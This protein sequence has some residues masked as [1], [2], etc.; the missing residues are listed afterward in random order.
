MKKQSFNTDWTFGLQGDIKHPVCLPHDAMLV[1]GR[2]AKSPGGS[3]LGYFQGGTYEYEKTFIFSGDLEHKHFEIQF[4]SV[5]QNSKVFVNGTEAG[6]AAYGYIPFF[7][8]LDPFLNRG[9]ENTI[10]VVADNH[11]MP[12]SRWYTGGGIYRPVWLWIGNRSHIQAEGVKISTLSYSPA[13]ILVETSHTAGSDALVSVE[14]FDGETLVSSGQGTAAEL[15]I[16]DARLWS[17]ETP[18]LYT[19]RVTLTEHGTAVDEAVETFGIRKI[20]WSNQGFLVNGKQ[21]LLRGGCLHHDN[22][23]LGARTYDKSEFRRVRKLKEAGYNAIR[24]SHNPASRAMLD[25]CDQYGVYLIDETWDMWFHHKNKFDYASCWRENY[26]SDILAMVNRDFNHPCVIMYSIG[27]EVS[28]PAKTEGL[29]V[30]RE[31]VE[32]LHHLDRNRAVTAGLNLMIINTSSKGKGVYNEEGGRTNDNDSMFNGMSST[33]FNLITS[34]VGTGM[35][36]SANSNAADKATTPCLDVLDIAGYNYN[37]GRYPMEGK[38]H[39]DRVI[40]GS[41]TFPQDI[42][43]NWNMVK[44][45]PYLFGD[46]MWTAWDYL[47]EAGLGAWAYTRDGKAFNKPY[48]WLLAECG[49]FDILGNPGAPVAC[50]QAAWALDNAPFVGV[51]PVNHPDVKPAKAVWRGTNAIAGWAWNG[52]EGNTALVEVY[53]SASTVKVFLN[54]KCLGEKK[55]KQCKAT[56]K[57]K[58]APGTLEAIVYDDSGNE[59]GRTALASVTGKPVIRI[60]PEETRVKPGDICYFDIALADEDGNVECNADERLTCK[61]EGGKLLAFG[62]ANP[63]T[64]DDYLSGSF[65]THY[66]RAQA[67]VKAGNTG[68]VSITVSGTTL[69]S[70]TL[71]IMVQ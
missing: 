11:E 64:E 40:Y 55:I 5:Y 69:E 3:A 38:S 47:G 12:N 67:I 10:T 45:F 54:G 17:E 43:K 2:D 19:C 37:S 22:G 28:E 23:I 51:Q 9:E 4:E 63:R 58:Y 52:C 44:E 34:F 6:G 21:T 56:Y 66:G 25:A 15:S 7:V 62:S 68:V 61:V 26:R 30:E 70:K 29:Q 46:F 35:N 65:T 39:P 48:P 1:Q 33:M 60:L 31:M 53:S 36:K 59:C 27:N 42:V 20:E 18:N 32:Y 50:A 14:I 16:P 8:D 41:E 49:A 24:S 71:E 13:R 57:T